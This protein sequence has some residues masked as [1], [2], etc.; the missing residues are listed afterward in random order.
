[1]LSC[2]YILKDAELYLS[3]LGSVVS[4]VTYPMGPP[5]LNRVEGMGSR[6]LAPGNWTPLVS[7][8]C[9]GG[10]MWEGMRMREKKIGTSYRDWAQDCC[11]CFVCVATDNRPFRNIYQQVQPHAHKHC[12]LPLLLRCDA[13]Q[14]YAIRIYVYTRTSMTRD[15]TCI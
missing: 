12:I 9:S 10:M 13:T 7:P 15:A 1:M 4:I 8:V 2:D 6:L 3:H 14:R 5:G 11:A